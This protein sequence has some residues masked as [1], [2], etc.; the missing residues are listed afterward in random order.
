MLP[1]LTFYLQFVLQ[2]LVAQLAEQSAVIPS[3]SFFSKKKESLRFTQRK[4]T[5]SLRAIQ[6]TFKKSFI[7]KPKKERKNNFFIL[8]EQQPI[9]R[10][11]KSDP[12]RQ[13]KKAEVAQSGYGE[14]LLQRFR[15]W[16]TKYVEGF[17]I[18]HKY[19]FV[20]ESSWAQAL[21]GSNPTLCV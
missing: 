16:V 2:A 5:E 14:S 8:E 11:F 19:V 6:K 17:S 21:V 18:P 10:R 3:L 20:V 4:K 7:K 12:R 15:P 1:F 9:G 13:R